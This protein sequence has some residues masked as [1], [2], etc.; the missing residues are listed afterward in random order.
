MPFDG[1]HPLNLIVILVVALLIFGPKKLP[2]MGKAIG[3]SIQMFRKGMNELTNTIAK[4][5]DTTEET[6]LPARTPEALRQELEELE[7][8]IANRKAAL[9]QQEVITPEAPVAQTEFTST[10]EPATSEVPTSTDEVYSAPAATISED[11]VQPTPEIVTPEDK[12][13]PVSKDSTP[14][15]EVSPSEFSQT[16]EKVITKAD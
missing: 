5:E 10:E 14:R 11:G 3:Q 8:E 1:F 6:R 9:A 13:H 4:D 15:A 7:R 16:D 2:E 12:E